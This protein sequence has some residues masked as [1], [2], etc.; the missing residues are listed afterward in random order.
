LAVYPLNVN[1]NTFWSRLIN[2]NESFLKSHR[3]YSC[4]GKYHPTAVSRKG[5]NAL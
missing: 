2:Y 5:C 1:A 3:W 4:I